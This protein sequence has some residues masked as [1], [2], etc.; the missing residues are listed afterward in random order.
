V[1]VAMEQDLSHGGRAPASYSVTCLHNTQT[2]SGSGSCTRKGDKEKR[3]NRG[4]RRTGSARKQRTGA[5]H[6][7]STAGGWEQTGRAHAKRAKASE[8]AAT[9]GSE[10]E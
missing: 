8:N 10:R 5:V 3:A 1:E 9:D 7:R 6:R 4:H 2:G